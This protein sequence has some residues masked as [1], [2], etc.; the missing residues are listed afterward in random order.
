M[1]INP[2]KKLQ[3]IGRLASQAPYS[4]TI[5]ILQ[6][7]SGVFSFIGLP[8][9]VPVLNYLGNSQTEHPQKYLGLV[10][11]V[12]GY[13][14]IAPSFN[15]LL[16]VAFILIIFGTVLVTICALLAVFSQS[17]FIKRYRREVFDAYSRVSW[18]WLIDSRSGE[19][20][21][22][23][24]K[25]VERAA[26]APL[27]A[28]RVIIYL[29]QII[30][31]IAVA[32]KISV[33]V[34]LMA[35][36]V[37]GLLAL[38]NAS[39][40]TAIRRI[41]EEYGHY[42]MRLSNAMT[43]LQQN[44]KFFK[45]SLLNQQLLRPILQAI[46]DLSGTIKRESLIVQTQQITNAVLTYLFLF[47]LMFFHQPLSLG[48]SDLLLVLAIFSRIAPNFNMVSMCYASLDGCIPMYESLQQR[49]GDLRRHQ[50]E[51]GTRPFKEG[52]IRFEHAAFA[53]PNGKV[54][55][56]DLYLTIRP[57]TTTAFVGSSGVGKST[58]LDLLLG[59]LKPTGGH[60][61]YGDVP[62]HE[63]DKSSLRKITAYVAQ[64]VT[65]VN[66]TLREN[67]AIRA[68]DLEEGRIQSV[69][70][71][72]GLDEVIAQMPQGLDTPVGENG[73]KLS[74]GQKQRVA[75]ARAL[76]AEP[77]ILILDEATSSLDSASESQIQQTIR[78]LQK[79]LTIIIVSHKL[80]S[81]RYADDIFV[82]D[83]YGVCECGNYEQL[84]EKK[85]KLHFFDSLQ[86]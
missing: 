85:G 61:Y 50:E 37:Y 65:L 34:T 48:Y 14:G 59:L 60:I 23:V 64:D 49:L 80:S 5:L 29:T 3:Y 33:T 78:N 15:V 72:V 67:L 6:F 27:D 41:G 79:E 42:Y 54:V 43:T 81:V 31:L 12:L 28:Q 47:V 7:L 11:K 75:L 1:T 62:H 8:M 58:L 86:Q 35:M 32:L 56:K 83:N 21:F 17:E 13:A 52:A 39:G 16:A 55:F 22:S 71:K 30:V 19:L 25:E 45:T 57:N 20:H 51:N 18:P 40:S 66:G 68:A 44:K 46:D 74:G 53:Y 9:L 63:L 70:K 36:A 77:K 4:K 24:M 2:V 76:F 73:V 69:I 38:W 26:Q 84:L 82:L 10:D